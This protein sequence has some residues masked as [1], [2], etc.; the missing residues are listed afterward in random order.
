MIAYLA[1]TILRKNEKSIIVLVGGIGYEVFTLPKKILEAAIGDEIKLL[2]YL[3]IK[4]NSWNLYGFSDQESLDFFKLLLTI[5]GIGPK[6]ALNILSK[7][8]LDILRQAI[9]ANNPELLVKISG[10][11]KKTAEVVVSQL[12]D[13]VG[14][15]IANPTN[16][17]AD[18]VNSEL[19]E[20]LSQLGY[21]ISQIR[22][23]LPKISP[24]A[25]SIEEKIK[26]ALKLI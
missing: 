13:K 2:T 9:T 16:T 15:F 24:E 19:I 12:K 7:A 22:N 23:V 26:A 14:Q 21:D 20:V 11:G 4:E 1:G 6:S 8:E 25:K 10:L 5:S 18:N 3:D 17:L